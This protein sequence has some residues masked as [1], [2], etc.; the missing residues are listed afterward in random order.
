MLMP[1]DIVNSPL[2]EHLD[3]PLDAPS[4]INVR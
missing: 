3:E 2:D 1:F 4:H